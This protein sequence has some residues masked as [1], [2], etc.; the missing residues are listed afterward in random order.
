MA[1]P[2]Q[3]YTEPLEPANL[4]KEGNVAMGDLFDDFLDIHRDLID[5]LWL[6]DQ[7]HWEAAVFHW[8]QLHWHWSNHVIGA[9]HAL[10]LFE[11]EN[12]M[13]KIQGQSD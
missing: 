3:Y 10:H 13:G 11:A 8:R 1:L 12:S 5:G 7:G 4:E 2:F 9:L 6:L